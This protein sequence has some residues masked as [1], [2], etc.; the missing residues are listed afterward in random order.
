LQE[1]EI[2]SFIKETFGESS[3]LQRCYRNWNNG[4]SNIEI[5]FR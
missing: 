1:K 2:N 4:M 5:S 3:N